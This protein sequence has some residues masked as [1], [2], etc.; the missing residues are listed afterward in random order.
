MNRIKK[1]AK[2]KIVKRLKDIRKAGYHHEDLKIAEK[3]NKSEY[4]RGELNGFQ[5][6][7]YLILGDEQATKLIDKAVRR[8]NVHT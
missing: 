1:E 2:E 3:P 8:N 6:A 4:C 7:L 5:D